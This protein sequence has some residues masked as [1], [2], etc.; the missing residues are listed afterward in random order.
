MLEDKE[1][2]YTCDYWTLGSM[3]GH[4]MCARCECETPP[5]STCCY[6]KDVYKEEDED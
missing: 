5:G 6:W 3:N 4:G 1:I 2:C